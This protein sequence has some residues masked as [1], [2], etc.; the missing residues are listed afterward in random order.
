MTEF[1]QDLD[2]LLNR[3][4][5]FWSTALSKV[6]LWPKTTAAA[7]LGV[8]ALLVVA[9]SIPRSQQDK[10]PPPKE[11]RLNQM[12]DAVQKADQRIRSQMGPDAEPEP[13]FRGVF[14]TMRDQPGPPPMPGGPPPVSE[15]NP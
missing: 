14:E 5:Q 6:I 3:V 7:G 13:Q 1:E 2:R 11:W 8:V 12:M 10:P 4:S 15:I 9:W